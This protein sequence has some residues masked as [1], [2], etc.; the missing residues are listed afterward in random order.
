[1]AGKKATNKTQ[2]KSTTPVESKSVSVYARIDKLID[3]E[4]SKVKAIA[5]VN[6]GNAFAVHGIRV[7]ESDKG[8]FVSMPSNSYQK[9]GKTEYNEIFHPVTKEARTELESHVIEAYEQK[10]QE[11]QGKEAAF[12][13][14]EEEIPNFGQEM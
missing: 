7:I 8:L 6:I 11:E 14:D 12:A 5:S 4:Q 3:V 1:M 2:E 9:N 13:E 10:L